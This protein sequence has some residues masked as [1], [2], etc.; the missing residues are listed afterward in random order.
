MRDIRRILCP[1]DYSVASEHALAQASAIA[2]WF[3]ATVTVLHVTAPMRALP[4]PLQLG[5]LPSEV[6]QP[7]LA[8]A[9]H[10]ALD[11][12]EPPA[13]AG[14]VSFDDRHI[15]SYDVKASILDC[16]AALPADLLVM[17]THGRTGLAWLLIGSV[18]DHVLRHAPC[19]VLTVP[20]AA[21][22]LSTPPFKRVLCAVDF[23]PAS[24]AAVRV[25]LTFAQEGDARLTLLYVFPDP[26]STDAPARDTPAERRRRGDAARY[27]LETLIGPDVGTF[28]RPEARVA[29]GQ[30]YRRIV[31]FSERETSDLIVMGAGGRSVVERVFVG[32]TTNQVVRRAACPVLTVRP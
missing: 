31:E 9:G 18:T 32:S 23:S 29:W 3:D 30:P 16:A 15:E 10:A 11:A 4:G 2:R 27:R 20:P 12:C 21:E 24:L 1:I 19:P 14:G 28:C 6:L 7:V 8:L 26:S 22:R 17:G 25:A 13:R 5:V